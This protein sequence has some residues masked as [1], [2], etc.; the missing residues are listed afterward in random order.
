MADSPDD[1][2]QASRCERL[3]HRPETVG[4]PSSGH[5][6]Q[7]VR[8]KAQGSKARPVR[9]PELEHVPLPLAPEHH[10]LLCRLSLIFLSA[11]QEGSGESKAEIPN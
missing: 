6:Q 2:E 4:I 7:L 9:L 1:R 8:R 11:M 5:H 3:L 10:A